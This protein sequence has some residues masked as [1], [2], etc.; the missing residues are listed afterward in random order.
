MPAHAKHAL[1]KNAYM[2]APGNTRWTNMVRYG[3]LFRSVPSIFLNAS[4]EM[5]KTSTAQSRNWRSGYAF[6]LPS[7]TKGSISTTN[8]ICT[9]GVMVIKIKRLSREN[10]Q[11]SKKNTFFHYSL[12]FFFRH[13][14]FLQ[15][16]HTLTGSHRQLSLLGP[17]RCAS[18]PK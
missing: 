4:P 13:A 17:L 5:D 9:I 8:N 11:I 10:A 1:P 7:G 3:S 16:T 15:L 2:V 6:R 14:F 12:S 18:L